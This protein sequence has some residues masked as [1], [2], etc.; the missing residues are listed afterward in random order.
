MALG[1]EL[2]ILNRPWSMFWTAF[3]CRHT[4]GLTGEQTGRTNQPNRLIKRKRGSN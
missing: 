2:E 1:V 4:K 3:G